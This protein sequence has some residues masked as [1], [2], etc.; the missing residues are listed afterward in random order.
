MTPVSESVGDSFGLGASPRTSVAWSLFDLA[1]P[2]SPNSPFMLIHNVENVIN[3][4]Q[5]II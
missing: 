3:G 4:L 5:Q 2:N 1:A